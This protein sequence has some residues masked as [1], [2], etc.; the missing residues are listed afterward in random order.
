MSMPHI[1]MRWDYNPE[2]LSGTFF[3]LYEND[4][5]VVDNI[6]NPYFDLTMEGKEYGEYTYRVT[7]VRKD[8]MIE[9]S[10]SNP[11]VANFTQPEAPTNLRAEFPDGV[12]SVSGSV[13]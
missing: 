2:N 8:F 11:Y 12:V 3:R 4:E 1:P 7:A 10:P 5:L 9:S 6:A 13:G